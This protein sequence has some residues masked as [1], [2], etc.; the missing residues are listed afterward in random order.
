[1]V[2]EIDC[3]PNMDASSAV[4]DWDNVKDPLLVPNGDYHCY[5][6]QIMDKKGIRYVKDA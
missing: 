1:M 6:K 4:I 5:C 3:Q 2:P